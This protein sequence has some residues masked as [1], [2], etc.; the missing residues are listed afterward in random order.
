MRIATL[1]AV[2]AGALMLSCDTAS[3]PGTC[4]P[5]EPIKP[6]KEFYP[7]GCSDLCMQCRC[8]VSEDSCRWV[9]ICC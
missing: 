6:P 2:I 3:P 8:G 4:G 1:L 7:A 9:W 5:L